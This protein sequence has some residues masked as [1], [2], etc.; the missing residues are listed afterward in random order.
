MDKRIFKQFFRFVVIGIINTGIDFLVLNIEMWLTGIT[1]GSFMFVQ[2]AVS[3]GVATINSYFLNKKWAFEDTSHHDQAKKFS[4]FMSVSIV[5]ILI[6]S[7]IVYLITTF[8]PP[9]LGINDV[10]WANLAKVF[11]TGI[12]LVWNFIGY[13]FLVFK[14]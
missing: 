8:I 12:S 3:F 6:N 13:K 11:A 7:T 14:K 2:N 9:L 1:S 4:S 10:L 5:G